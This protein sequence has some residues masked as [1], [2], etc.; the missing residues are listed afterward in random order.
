MPPETPIAGLA[1][2]IQLAVAPVFLLSGIAGLLGVLTSRLARI[3]DR[4]RQLEASLP[5]AVRPADAGAEAELRVLTVRVRHINRAITLCTYAAL[6]VAGVVA[7][8]FIG[9]V[10]AMDLTRVVAAAFVLAM[11]ALIA[12]L[13]SFLREIH[14]AT[15][16][17]REDARRIAGAG[18][19]PSG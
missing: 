10:A 12:G 13:T 1:H 15:R 5:T 16:H 6:L 8:L 18:G 2:A 9:A 7:T 19:P 11:L 3:I 17:Y 14:V 4:S